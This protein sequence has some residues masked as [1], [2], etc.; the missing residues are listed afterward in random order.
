MLHTFH[1]PL[2]ALHEITLSLLSEQNSDKLLNAILDQ[3]IEFT[4]SDSGSIA[5]LNE[6]RKYL[7][8]KAHRGLS[9]D[10]SEKVKLK[11]GEGVTGRCILTGK[12][13]NVGDTRQDPHYI[14]V[15]PDIRSELAV[16]LKVG[17]KSFGVISVDS[18]RLQAFNREHEEYIELLASYA[19]QILTNHQALTNL[20]HRTE[21]L[22]ALL[23]ISSYIGKNPDFETTFKEIMNL[24]GKKIGLHRGAVFLIDEI[25]NEL[26]LVASAGYTDEEKQ[27][28][29]Y[30]IGEGITGSVF[31]DNKFISIPDIAQDH[32]F[33]NKTGHQR[34]DGQIMSFFA[35]PVRLNSEV[36]G[37][38]SMEVPYRSQSYFEDYQFLVQ[39]TTSLFGQALRIQQL[40]D[41]KSSEVRSENI[42]LKRQLYKD[43]GFN[44]LIGASPKMT[45]LFEKMR[46]AA[47]TAS[48]VLL[49]GESGTGKEMIATALHQNSIRRDE[50][51]VKL[52]CAAIPADLLE[53]E[54]FGYVKGAFTG[55]NEDRKGRVLAAHKGTLFLDEIGEMDYRLQSKL[56]R[57]LQ[58]KE[59]SPLG[60]N[61]VYKVDVRIIAA[62]NANLEKLIEE[63]KFREDLYYRLN[64]IRLD[65]PPLRERKEDI[66]LLVQ[67]LTEKIAAAN[68][69]KIKGLTPA[70]IQ[71][72]LEYDFPGNV[73]ELENIL[74][75]A[76]VLTDRNQIDA[77]DL[78]LPET[79]TLEAKATVS[80]NQETALQPVSATDKN[81]NIRSWVRAQ[82][83]TVTEG[84]V[85][86]AV[87]SRI[88][89]ELISLVLQNNLFNK[90]KTAK[91]L[92]INR[93]T[94]DRKIE[95]YK[96]L[97]DFRE[98]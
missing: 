7:E 71:R 10:V 76:I 62:T 3:A 32:N 86:Y 8:I 70:A 49:I 37:V 81:F 30:S 29:R 35:A 51:M 6:N 95:E 94:L 41:E 84:D 68:R 88:E 9:H 2:V 69:K 59:F 44:N 52:N 53:S 79:K 11:L 42:A 73:R 5:L 18:S 54:L 36:R 77:S 58:E 40:I 4:K 27:K 63:K 14:E 12:T 33:L 56:L 15:R 25:S 74:E 92:G 80:Q 17:S 1:N 89:K 65:I 91:I 55:A 75:R 72:L 60:S 20:S 93:L 24:L 22:E 19:A 23:E 82:L 39:I 38:F 85:R 46:M 31:K 64:V 21:I 57:V 28:A 90:T 47:D 98:T 87:I 48:S 26:Y 34:D 78:L 16:P 96:I 66:P 43:Y 67:H 45:A 13:R 61:K 97:E 83:Q 50:T